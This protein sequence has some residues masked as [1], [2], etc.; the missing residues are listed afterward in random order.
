MNKLTQLSY[1]PEKIP[2]PSTSHLTLLLKEFCGRLE[3]DGQ[4]GKLTVTE[5][6]KEYH[7]IDRD[8]YL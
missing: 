6:L 7:A 4:Q 2:T 8:S 1:K 3:V 5:F